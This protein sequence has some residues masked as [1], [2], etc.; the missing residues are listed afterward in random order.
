MI[1]GQ[2]TEVRYAGESFH[3]QT[4]DKGRSNPIIESLVYLG[5][6][7]LAAVRVD[8]SDLLAEGSGAEEIAALMNRQHRTM[9]AAILRGRLDEKVAGMGDA[10]VEEIGSDDTEVAPLIDDRELTLD[11]M[12]LGYLNER[13]EGDTLILSLDRDGELA[14][15]SDVGLM[16]KAVSSKGDVPIEAAE[17][18]VRVIRA[19][20]PPELLASGATGSAGIAEL[21]VQIPDTG[22]GPA[23]LIVSARSPIGR[24]ELKYLLR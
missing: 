1:T 5:G 22:A 20:S 15:G 23:A 12:I 6:Q 9:I 11:E 21:S 7:V 8:Y 10:E 18:E 17:I 13:Q 16:V 19:E 14:G 4:E 24:A 3:V 2:N